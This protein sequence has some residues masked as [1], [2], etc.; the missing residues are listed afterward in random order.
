VSFAPNGKPIYGPSLGLD[1]ELEMGYF[2]SKPVTHGSELDI[3]NA[4]QHIFGFVLLNDW[5]SRDLQLFEMK[6]LGPFN[7]KSGLL[8]LPICY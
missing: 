3:K 8:Q 1:Y 5:S 4:D 7:G 2:V 6:P